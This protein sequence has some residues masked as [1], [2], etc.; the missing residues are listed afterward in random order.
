M[1]FLTFT[2]CIGEYGLSTINIHPPLGEQ[3]LTERIPSWESPMTSSSKHMASE[4]CLCVY[5]KPGF[6]G[7]VHTFGFAKNTDSHQVLSLAID[8]ICRILC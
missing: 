5:L 2:Q 7:R 6:K 8:L 4:E 1:K 3:G